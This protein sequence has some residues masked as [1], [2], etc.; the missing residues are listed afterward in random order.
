MARAFARSAQ[1]ADQFPSDLLVT[2]FTTDMGL[3]GPVIDRIGQTS[4]GFLW[5][6][7]NGDFL[8]RFGKDSHLACGACANA[9]IASERA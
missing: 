5:L 7:I 9:R 2:H 6:L 1:S 8:S 4:D 3:P